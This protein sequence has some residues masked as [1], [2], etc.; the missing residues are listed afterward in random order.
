VTD[1]NER[2]LRRELQQGRGS[3]DGA[4]DTV[5][6]MSYQGPAGIPQSTQGD[7]EA[8]WIKAPPF[9]ASVQP[10][11]TAVTGGNPNLPVRDYVFTPPIDVEQRRVLSVWVDFTATAAGP[12]SGLSIVPQVFNDSAGEGGEFWNTVVIDPT[13][14]VIDLSAT[15]LAMPGV[16]SRV[17]RPAELRSPVLP[18]LARWQVSIPFDVTPWGKFRLAV[19]VFG[20]MPMDGSTGSLRLGYSFAN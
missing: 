15:V 14:S 7:N 9:P 18:L 4:A 20:T 13:L 11:F 2:D 19:G 3:G 12:L 17:F 10:W 1:S 6:G 16:G 5:G 8:P